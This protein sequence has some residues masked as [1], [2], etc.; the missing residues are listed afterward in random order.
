MFLK[1]ALVTGLVAA[2]MVEGTLPPAEASETKPSRVVLRDGAGDV[3]VSTPDSSDPTKTSFPAADVTRAVARH[4]RYAVRVRM[5]FVDLRRSGYQELAAHIETPRLD[6]YGYGAYVYSQPG[7]RRGWAELYDENYSDDQPIRCDGLRHRFNYD[8]N[9][10]TLR[11]PRRCL[12]RPQ[13]VK[14]TIGSNMT[15]NS[16]LENERYYSDNPHNHQPWSETG[17]RRLYR[18]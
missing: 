3:W 18:R 14:V 11:I 1:T 4:A 12:G 16:S 13:W 2:T 8:K 7:Q 5:R 10:V 17:T 9:L 15:V 6:H